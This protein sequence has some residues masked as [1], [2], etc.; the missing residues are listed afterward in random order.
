MNYVGH[1]V[2][3]SAGGVEDRRALVGGLVHVHVERLAPAAAN[4]LQLDL[5]EHLVVAKVDLQDQG[6]GPQLL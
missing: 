6:L 3:V 4:E 5:V 2:G 1:G